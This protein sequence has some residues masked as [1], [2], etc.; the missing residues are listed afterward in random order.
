MFVFR[1]FTLKGGRIGGHDRQGADTGTATAGTMQ[2]T[3]GRELQQPSPPRGIY[4]N[5][6]TIHQD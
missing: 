4:R 5:K 2:D 1:I 3:L 6:A